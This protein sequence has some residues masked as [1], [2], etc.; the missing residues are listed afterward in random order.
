[1]NNA[2]V[3]EPTSCI[4]S[5]VWLFIVGWNSLLCTHGPTRLV[6]GCLHPAVRVA[7]AVGAGCVGARVLTSLVVCWLGWPSGL[8]AW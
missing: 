2:W 4:Y 5:R 8:T 3:Q 6:R 1:M 7:T